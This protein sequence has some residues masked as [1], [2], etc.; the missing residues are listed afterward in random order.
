MTLRNWLIGLLSVLA[1]LLARGDT[2]LVSLDKFG[3]QMAPA[4]LLDTV[5][6]A[7]G[8]LSLE[9]ALNRLIFQG[10]LDLS[11]N[12]SRLPLTKIVNISNH[13]GTVLDLLNSIIAQA[14]CD[15]LITSGGQLVIVPLP[16]LYKQEKELP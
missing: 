9:D 8:P 2:T 14:S 15:L 7:P 3:G 16:N 11:F 13:P 4:A 12:R 10:N 5:R 6:I 1:L